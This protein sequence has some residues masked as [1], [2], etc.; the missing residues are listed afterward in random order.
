MTKNIRV[1]PSLVIT[2]CFLLGAQSGA[3]ARKGRQISVAVDPSV[4]SGSPEV[5]LVEVSDYRCMV[6]RK[7]AFEVLP[8]VYDGFVRPG[9]VELV[10]LDLPLDMR[11]PSFQA[12]EAAACADEQNVFWEM[13]GLLFENPQALAPADLAG[14]AE[15]LNLD[16]AAFKTCLSTGKHA[17]GIRED[18]RTAGSFG[19]RGTPA[20]LLGRRVSGGD[21]IEVLEVVNGLPPYEVL[22]E[23]LDALLAS[24]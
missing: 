13:H 5:V 7:G 8:K 16:V 23:K 22:K 21:K 11:S 9:K 12:A 4:K 19:I 6:C 18:V 3:F 24:K 10:F 15:Q 17:G 20:Y 2:A 14:Y 1:I